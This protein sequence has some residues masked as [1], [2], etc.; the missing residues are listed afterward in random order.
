MTDDQVASL[1]ANLRSLDERF[2][3]QGGGQFAN[4]LAD[5]LNAYKVDAERYRWLREN[6]DDR[7]VT[8]KDGYGGYCLRYGTWLDTA[9]DNVLKGT[10]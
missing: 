6:G 1:V 5:L 8:E 9:I 2:I 4:D 7:R 10:E 3:F